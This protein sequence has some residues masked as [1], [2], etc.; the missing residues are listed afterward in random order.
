[1]KLGIRLELSTTQEVPITLADNVQHAE[2]A[3]NIYGVSKHLPV[4]PENDVIETLHNTKVSP[5]LWSIIKSNRYLLVPYAGQSPAEIFALD[6][7]VHTKAA[8][9]FKPKKPM[10]NELLEQPEKPAWLAVELSHEAGEQCNNTDQIELQQL[11]VAHVLYTCLVDRVLND[12]NEELHPNKR[13]MLRQH[14][15]AA[16]SRTMYRYF[17]DPKLPIQ[18]G[19]TEQNGSL[20]LP[21]SKPGKY[22]YAQARG[23]IIPAG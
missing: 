5:E 16:S 4:N 18:I 2:H 7:A 20:I 1:M 22:K 21:A 23:V 15:G 6:A 14:T 17:S 12:A 3:V 8:Q 10:L 11:S 9:E 13:L 19:S